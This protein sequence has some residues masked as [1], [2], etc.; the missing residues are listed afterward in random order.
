V[1]RI[2]ALTLLLPT[3]LACGPP[4]SHSAAAPA[5]TKQLAASARAQYAKERQ[6]RLRALEASGSSDEA[7]TRAA[8]AVFAT[9]KPGRGVTRPRLSVP[10][11]FRDGC[12]V[13]AGYLNSAQYEAFDQAFPQSASFVAWPAPKYRTPAITHEDGTMVAEWVL[14]RPPDGR[15][16][17][18]R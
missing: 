13:T 1:S 6:E 11:C 5:E 2:A 16:E 12:V 10:R 8:A 9:W 3:V 17:G 15:S 4:R 7:W 18:M 14:L